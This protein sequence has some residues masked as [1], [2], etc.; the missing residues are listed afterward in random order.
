[1]RDFNDQDTNIIPDKE[2]SGGVSGAA[3]AGN[4]DIKEFN[5]E[6]DNDAAARRKKAGKLTSIVTSLLA[7]SM[8]GISVILPNVAK[9][10]AQASIE[11]VWATDSSVGCFVLADGQDGLS[12]VISNYFT[13]RTFDIE[14]GENTFTA[15][16]LKPNTEYK[17][18]VRSEAYLGG[19]TVLAS[20]KIRTEKS[21]NL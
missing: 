21:K 13:K 19:S 5:P 20:K 18:E 8:L 15:E 10:S 9:S 16:G 3:F 17:V 4:P 1:M 12:V 14:D 11:D 2:Y 6:P 7:V